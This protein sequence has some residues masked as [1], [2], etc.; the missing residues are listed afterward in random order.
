MRELE[1][2][3][4]DIRTAAENLLAQNAELEAD[5]ENQKKQIMSLTDDLQQSIAMAK[6]NGE[7]ADKLQGLLNEAMKEQAEASHLRGQVADLRA[8]LGEVRAALSAMTE[9]AVRAETQAE[10][11]IKAEAAKP[12][13]KPNH[14]PE[15][16]SQYDL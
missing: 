10:G 1:E 13:P 12:A 14:G 6:T 7:R 11:K 4:K 2:E 15:K 3:A 8:E 5:R 9:R 16:D